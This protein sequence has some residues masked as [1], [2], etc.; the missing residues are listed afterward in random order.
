MNFEYYYWRPVNMNIKYCFI[1]LQTYF[2]S[3]KFVIFDNRKTLL[4]DIS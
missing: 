2:L 3:Y 4:T 1:T